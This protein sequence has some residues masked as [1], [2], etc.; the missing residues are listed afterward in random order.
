MLNHKVIRKQF[1]DYKTGI[2]LNYLH[3]YF[4]VVSIAQLLTP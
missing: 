2:I 4:D 1:F 3:P